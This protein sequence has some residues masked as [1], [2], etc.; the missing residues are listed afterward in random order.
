[1]CL[2]IFATRWVLQLTCLEVA[3]NINEMF[4]WDKNS[5]FFKWCNNQVV[6]E[7]FVWRL[8]KQMLQAQPGLL[9]RIY[10]LQPLQCLLLTERINWDYCSYAICKMASLDFSE[11]KSRL[12]FSQN[13]YDYNDDIG[14][15]EC[16]LRWH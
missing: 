4:W 15:T 10:D 6:S 12:E 2:I 5:S 3:R 13:C 7:T 1:M 11:A 8:L 16:V 9:K 14:D